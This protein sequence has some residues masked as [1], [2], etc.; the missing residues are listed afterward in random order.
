MVGLIVHSKRPQDVRMFILTP[1]FPALMAIES[2]LDEEWTP[3]MLEEV[4]S[5]LMSLSVGAARLD[6]EEERARVARSRDELGVS[7]MAG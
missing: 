1:L 3:C 7:L 6:D 5:P 2:R 4:D